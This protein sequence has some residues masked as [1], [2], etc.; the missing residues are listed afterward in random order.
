MGLPDKHFSS[1]LGKHIYVTLLA[2]TTRRG[3]L[4]KCGAAH[5]QFIP[6]QESFGYLHCQGSEQLKK[7]TCRKA[8]GRFL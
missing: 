3:S 5:L 6:T 1:Q 7:L 4:Q 2:I 8:S